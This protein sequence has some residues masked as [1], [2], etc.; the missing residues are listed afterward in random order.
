MQPPLQVPPSI[1]K[2]I[3]DPVQCKLFRAQEHLN[4]LQTEIQK[5]YQSD[6]AKVVRKPEG[7]SDQFIPEMV[8]GVPIPK[9]IPLIIGDF[10]QNLRSSLDYLVW[11]LVTAAKNTPN[12][13]NMFPIC[14]TPEAFKAQIARHRLHGVPADAVAEIETLQP[15]HSEGGPDGNV[16]AMID[17]LCNI[18]KHRR[19]L[20]TFLFA[21]QAPP[22]FT[23]E[24]INGQLYGSLS[25]DSLHKQG[26]E[27]GSFTMVDGPYGL[28]PQM[29]VPLHCIAF[30]AF[31]DGP[32]QNVE[33][34]HTL[35]ILGGY[36]VQELA[37]FEKFFL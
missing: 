26:T 8:A 24:E 33:V 16:L 31:N 11:E 28:G 29:D 4:E 20:T 23:I 34:G 3:P 18:N 21:A 1:P 36:V 27:L 19:I 12:H 17:D 9:R 25:F 7:P 5:Y 13:N 32:A 14:A 2:S 30:V 10:L 35:S 22:D 37:R 6:P 15:Y